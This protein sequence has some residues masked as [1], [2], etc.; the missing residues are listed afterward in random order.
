MKK[1]KSAQGLPLNIIII[2]V[3]VLVVLVVLVLVF[4]GKISQW[5]DGIDEQT[6]NIG[7]EC[8]IPGTSRTCIQSLGQCKTEIISGSFT[9]CEK[10]FGKSHACCEF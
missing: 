2:A 9:D 7:K 5:G 10:R 6:S 3:I 8:E 4:R 1:K